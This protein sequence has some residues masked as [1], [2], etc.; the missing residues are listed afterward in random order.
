TGS[1]GVQITGV[2]DKYTL[3]SQIETVSFKANDASGNPLASGE[4]TVTDAGVSQ[5]VHVQ[6][7]SGVATFT[8][9][10]FAREHPES[11]QISV[12]NQ[13]NV[14]STVSPSTQLEFFYQIL[15]DFLLFEALA[16]G[17]P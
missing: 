6:N 13:A 11:H 2:T 7:G 14:V 8:F 5:L 16:G 12:N 15:F 10:L 3:I 4:V 17:V 9:S 1:L